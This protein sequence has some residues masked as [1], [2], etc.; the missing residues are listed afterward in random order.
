[1]IRSRV[2]YFVFPTAKIWLTGQSVNFSIL[3][4]V[5]AFFKSN[6]SFNDGNKKQFRLGERVGEQM[7]ERQISSFFLFS[8]LYFSLAFL[9]TRKKLWKIIFPV[10]I[11]QNNVVQNGTSLPTYVKVCKKTIYMKNFVLNNYIWI[12][13]I[14]LY[15]HWDGKRFE[16][17]GKE[18]FE[19]FKI[20]L[21]I[22]NLLLIFC[23]MFVLYVI[24]III[25]I[26]A[27]SIISLS[28]WWS[29]W[30]MSLNT[31]ARNLGEFN[32]LG[33]ER[34]SNLRIS[35]EFFACKTIF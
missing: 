10:N 34:Y 28:K 12:K 9:I 33:L 5:L 17:I 32:L 11:L 23:L 6:L 7:D 19:F 29:L 26:C 25:F 27:W 31:I 35:F 2:S 13:H 16:N 22:N 30:L 8:S 3:K 20:S 24:I 18:L 1:M 4:N 15:T 21:A 14:S